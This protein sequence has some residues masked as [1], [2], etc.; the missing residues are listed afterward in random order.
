MRH[1]FICTLLCIQPIPVVAQSTR[2]LPQLRQAKRSDL[3]INSA[4][5]LDWEKRV[6]AKDPKV[7]AIAQAALVQGGA[8][9][10]SLL[11]RF[12][13]RRNEDLHLAT[14]EI[15]RRIGG[16]IAAGATGPWTWIGIGAGW[17]ACM[18]QDALEDAA[19]N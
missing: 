6:M 3:S 14:F 9:S 16:A 11:R 15:I 2:S 19:D 18:W 7:R 12:L 8:R 4:Q 1:L 17:A 13:N 5:L 10:L